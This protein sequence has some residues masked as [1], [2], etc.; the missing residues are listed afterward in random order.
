MAKRLKGNMRNNAGGGNS[1]I[2]KQPKAPAAREAYHMVIL[3]RKWLDDW[4][5]IQG[6][7]LEEK[8]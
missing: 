5:G 2:V 7:I 6:G 3:R 4:K 1:L 8:T